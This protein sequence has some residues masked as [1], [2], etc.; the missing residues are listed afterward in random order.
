[1][2]TFRDVI[3]FLNYSKITNLTIIK[4]IE[5]GNLNDFINIKSNDINSL[6]FLNDKDKDK[7]YS[8]F[9]KFNLDIYINQLYKNDINY[10]TILDK[11]YPDRLK[12]IF[13]PPAILFYRG[14]INI[15]K[16]PLAIVGTRKSSNYGKWVTHKIVKEL[17]SYNLSIVSGMA[18]GIDREA[19]ISAIEAGLPTIGV[20]A[21]SI[22]IM[23]PKG[24]LDL[25]NKMNNHLLISEYGINT[26]P[27]KLNF[28]L[29]NR[30]I[31]GLSFGLLVI[32][33]QELSGTLI[34]ASYALEQGREVFAVPGDID[35]LTSQG[36]NQL[37]AKGAKLV[38][39][40]NDIIEGLEFILEKEKLEPNLSLN[41][42]QD[43]TNILN[44]LE[45]NVL[46]FDL[47]SSRLKI[48]PANLYVIITK[49][50]MKG[51]VKKLDNNYYAKV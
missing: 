41:L 17:S 31:S 26:Y 46:N 2:K 42:S 49:L 20:L 4:L 40:A 44:L 22:D 16:N 10:I 39:S 15:I 37:I 21:S 27:M 11:T 50:E 1:M 43:E 6:N 30:I 29:R 7:L 8:S 3:L 9:E 5:N 33:A 25:Y 36:T 38:T 24:N 32:E 28:V 48:E 13:N 47:I 12:N 35:K 34:T 23:Y 51:L 19:H 14:N 18:L 45:Q